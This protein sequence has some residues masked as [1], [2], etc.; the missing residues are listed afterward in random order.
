MRVLVLGGTGFVGQFLVPALLAQGW[1][2]SV[3]ALGRGGLDPRATF[4]PGSR[5][6]PAD[7]QQ[8]GQSG[9][10]DAVIDL[11]AYHPHETRAMIDLWSGRTGRFVHLSTVSVYRGTPCPA[12]TEATAVRWTDT[13][14]SYGAEKAACES[15]LETACARTGFPCVIL[16]PA[17]LMGPGDPVSR[18]NYFLKRIVAEQPVLYPAE[19]IE[20][21]Y[22]SLLY[23]PDLVQAI[24]A[25]L[26]QPGVT[27]RAYHLAQ[28]ERLTLREHV[29]QIAALA[30]AR[31]RF[32]TVPAQSLADM[33]FALYAFPFGPVPPGAWLDTDRA[34]GELGFRPTP[35]SRALTATVS[36]YLE[37]GPAALPAWPGAGTRQSRLAGT[38]ELLHADLERHVL[39]ETAD[40]MAGALPGDTILE[41][42][43]SG[44]PESEGLTVTPPAFLARPAGVGDHR[45]FPRML[46]H[47][48]TGEL[49]AILEPDLYAAGE[50]AWFYTRGPAARARGF[51]SAA[52]VPRVRCLGFSRLNPDTV[53]AGERILATT[54]APR[55]AAAFRDWL[56]DRE[57]AGQVAIE[58]LPSY[59][60]VFLAGPQ[61]ESCTPWRR[62]FDLARLLHRAD[63][64]DE[65]PLIVRLSDP[66][67][68]LF[69]A[70]ATRLGPAGSV[71]KPFVVLAGVGDRFYL[72]DTEQ[73]RL[74]EIPY[75]TAVLIELL[76]PGD[77]DPGAVLQ[78]L[79]EVCSLPSEEA[80]RL[81]HS[82]RRMLVQLNLIR[83]AS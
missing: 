5:H 33:G 69:P 58:S 53:P 78:L 17:P 82:G 66:R 62:L 2:V 79:Q 74:Y 29:A 70:A 7:L 49:E 63:L 76:G 73:R 51:A 31:V 37:R 81:F 35:Y 40:R 21:G 34:V 43:T 75:H 12:V 3:F 26:V 41:C 83:I 11:I 8:L 10:Y 54:A 56:V 50:S 6:D 80:E 71:L 57:G 32:M 39:T 42:L 16:R 25:A 19:G 59:C 28:T 44:N 22:V 15:A 60:R 55:D 20:A 38:H 46:V 72:G 36:W 65:Q 24:L 47:R 14:G 1:D 45:D 4:L 61:A 18:E 77:A 68:P 9:D 27:G 13:D 64:A 23:V 67:R 30:G 48:A 52:L